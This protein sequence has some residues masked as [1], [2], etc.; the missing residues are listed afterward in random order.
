[1]KKFI[2]IMMA[3]ALVLC[4]AIPAHAVTPDLDVPDMPEIP[5][6][7]DEIDFGGIDF[8][9]I[10]DD[11]FAENPIPPL[12]PT[13]PVEVPTEPAEP[14]EPVEEPSAPIGGGWGDWLRGWPWWG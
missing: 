9:G 8:G 12:T 2:A 4:L 6:I 1:M 5:D 10:I 11:W 14:T 7:S 3:L 13:D